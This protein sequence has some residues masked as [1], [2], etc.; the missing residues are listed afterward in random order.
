MVWI[1]IGVLILSLS[2]SCNGAIEW[3]S[4]GSALKGLGSLSWSC[5]GDVV[6]VSKRERERERERVSQRGACEET[7]LRGE[8]LTNGVNGV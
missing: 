8:K 4:S 3:T 5:A 1:G 2:W 7:S 6:W